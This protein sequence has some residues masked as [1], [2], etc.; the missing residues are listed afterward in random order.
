MYIQD[1]EDAKP[2]WAIAGP[3]RAYPGPIHRTKNRIN[4]NNLLG[5]H[6]LF[7]P[8][9]AQS[10]PQRLQTRNYRSNFQ[11]TS[12]SEKNKIKHSH[13]FIS[14]KLRPRFKSTQFREI[15]TIVYPGRRK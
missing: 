9:P 2:Q 8:A 12:S 13:T 7:Y 15:I 3:L 10:F 14:N 1:V 6:R 11:W 4:R 5:I